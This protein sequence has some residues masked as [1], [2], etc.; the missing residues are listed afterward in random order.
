MKIT[1]Y[2][3][4]LMIVITSLNISIA[5]ADNKEKQAESMIKDKVI[6]LGVTDLSFHRATG[7]VVAN[8]LERMGYIV[9]RSFD[10]HKENFARLRS[11]EI[12]M[13]ASAWLPSSHG[14][15]KKGVEGATP[16]RELGLHYEPYALWGVPD[17]VPEAEVST[18][19]DLLK[20]AVKE[21]MT[22]TIQGIGAG[23][24][25]T[26]FSIKMMDEY[27][28]KGAG[29]TFLTGTQEQCIDAF[30]QAVAEKRWV[31][32]PLWHPQFLHN[33]YNIRELTDPKGL[34]CGK[35]RA[36]LLARQ[37]RLEQLFSEQEI[38]QLDSIKLSNEIIAELDYAINR[39][40][41]TEDEA[42]EAWLNS[43]QEKMGWIIDKVYSLPEPKQITIDKSL[44]S[45]QVEEMKLAAQNYAAFWDTGE[46]VYAK[47]ALAEDF[48]DL[49][50]PEGRKQ[51]PQGPL[52]RRN[53]SKPLDFG[54]NV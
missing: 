30:E 10:P 35:D 42:A 50:L 1:K 18:I 38:Q 43:N 41:K 53:R 22:P 7:A 26:R 24:G 19:S 27:R 14:V 9:I 13:I 11:G 36:V 28:L 54:I 51:A 2:L 21:K 29:Y 40:N 32:V 48:I 37:D 33:K 46:A 5:F 49:N 16:T 39:E 45:N 47:K 31:V 15:Y 6:K 23:A 17:Y 8:I 44:R 20:P 34:L 4:G 12:D 3:Y 25:I 52:A